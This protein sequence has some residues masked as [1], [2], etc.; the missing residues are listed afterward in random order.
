MDKEYSR[1]SDACTIK[2]RR[3]THPRA[4]GNTSHSMVRT[5]AVL[6][7]AT[8]DAVAA[9]APSHSERMLSS[10]FPSEQIEFAVARVSTST[11]DPAESSLRNRQRSPAGTLGKE[12]GGREWS[13]AGGVVGSWERGRDRAR[14]GKQRG[15]EGVAAGASLAF[16]T[17]RQ[18]AVYR[19]SFTWESLIGEE[20]SAR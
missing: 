2:H 4:S 15:K 10:R 8:R 16:T 9:G 17:G 19:M 12:Q 13:I 14:W 20:L 18:R 11:L 6:A 7:G 5:V 3:Y 1:K